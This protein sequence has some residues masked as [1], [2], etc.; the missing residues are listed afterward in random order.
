MYKQHIEFVSMTT[1]CVVDLFDTSEEVAQRCF[2]AIQENTRR[3]EHKYNFHHPD[4]LLNR[5]INQ[6]ATNAIEV[7]EESAHILHTV[8][9]LS[10]ATEG[11]FDITVGTIHDCFKQK[12]PAAMKQCLEERQGW[13]GLDSW[14]IQGQRLSFVHPETRIDLGGVIKEYA[15]DEAARL[16]TEQGVRSALI[17]FGG[18][19][20]VIGTKPDGRSF[21]VAIRNPIKRDHV[22]AVVNIE[23]QALTTS[24][25]YERVHKVG[26]GIFSHILSPKVVSGEILSSTMIGDTTLRC[27]IYSTAFMLNSDIAIPEALRVILVDRELRLHQN[28]L[29]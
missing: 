6:R 10:L 2:A 16:L 5:L 15:V 13:F 12:S 22:L 19:V 24:G 25:S 23:N 29:P 4:S 9:Q 17:N 3:L 1:Q 8:R 18:D 26:N 20:R 14:E 7:D 11:H 28:L 27:G 21:G